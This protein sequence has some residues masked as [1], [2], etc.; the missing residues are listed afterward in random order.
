M[1]AGQKIASDLLLRYARKADRMRTRYL[2]F[3]IDGTLA[4]GPI[5]RRYIPESAKRAIDLARAAGH[6]CAVA[7]GRSHAMAE[8]YRQELG[9]SLMVSDGGAGITI[10]GRL[11]A[12]EPLD[13][14][15]CLRLLEECEEKRVP[16][17][18]SSDDSRFRTTID[19]RF[20]D[21]VSEG[22]MDTIITPDLDFHD[23]PAFYKLYI[24]CTA[25]E[26]HRLSRLSDVP[27]A[28]FSPDCLFIE[29]VDKGAGIRCIMKHL[30]APAEDVIVFGDGSNDLSMFCPEWTCVAMGNA[31]DELKERADLVTTDAA[32]DGI[33]N[34]CVRLGLFPANDAS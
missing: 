26:E 21:A 15:P 29:P 34:A 14:E 13:R 12:L 33:W 22:Y 32:D 10:D 6:V 4:A 11:V 27:Q 18:I 31:I 16:W 5:G 9:L 28:R 25:A 7:T 20:D 24:A 8:P 1:N 17:A 19:R 3:D 23:V 30:N 2:F